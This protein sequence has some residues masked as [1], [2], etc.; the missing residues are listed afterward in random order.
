MRTLTSLLTAALLLLCFSEVQGQDR[1]N[2]LRGSWRLI[3]QQE[4]YV[5]T[6]I[7]R[8]KVDPSTKILNDSHFAFGFQSADGETVVAGGGRYT[9]KGDSYIEHIEYHS[10]PIL[11]GRDIE[12]KV[13]LDGN[14]WH[15]S[16]QIG[17]YRLE[18]V[19][20]RLDNDGVPVADSDSGG[21]P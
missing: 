12:F 11:V 5:D 16:G 20:V 3:A 6:V 10:S 18:E 14:K 17:D 19:W 9:L 15:H 8:Q 2:P 21:T 1:D 7:V 13:N 4:V